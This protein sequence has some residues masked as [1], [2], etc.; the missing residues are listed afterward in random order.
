[1]PAQGATAP[2]R[3]GHSPYPSGGTT[4]EGLTV[5]AANQGAQLADDVSYRIKA[6]WRAQPPLCPNAG[7]DTPASISVVGSRTVVV[8]LQ[9]QC[10]YLSAYNT[11]T[12]ALL[13]RHKYSAAGSESANLING[14][15]YFTTY[16]ANRDPIVEEVDPATGLLKW[17][18]PDNAYDQAEPSIGSGVL[19]RANRL[20]SATT[21]KQTCIA[22]LHPNADTDGAS[23]VADG[24]LFYNSDGSV[25]AYNPT[26]CALDWS[27][28]KSSA[29][30]TAPGSGTALPA[31]HNGLLYVRSLYDTA[32]VVLNPNTGTQVATLPTSDQPIAF[33]G[34]IGIF[35]ATPLNSS[36][37]VSAVNLSTAHVYW[38]RT[39]P[40]VVI[41]KF[42]DTEPTTLYA[43]PLIEDGL[44]WTENAVDTGLP[45]HID[46]WDEVT[47][48]TR[49]S[50]VEPCNAQYGQ[51]ELAIA[52]HR[53][54]AV[55]NCGVLTYTPS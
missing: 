4:V 43:P 34:A 31:Y 1:M 24:R 15:L 14:V 37:T 40:R 26:N 25:N 17:S 47:G 33:D 48:A 38:S 10:A 41:D 18:S 46:A 44:I 8:D 52:Q 19:A 32:T 30:V 22:S 45:A 49:S 21:G 6:S 53:V 11:S 9:Y 12:G 35:T 55:S 54:F 50:T 27:F 23:L 36:A 20:V 42:G 13:W 16:D 29:N 39:L 2:I 28:R 5:D 7:G 3:P 51:S